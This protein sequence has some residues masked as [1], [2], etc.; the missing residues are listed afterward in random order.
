MHQLFARLVV[1]AAQLLLISRTRD[2]TPLSAVERLQV[3]RKAHV[4]ADVVQVERAVVARRRRREALVRRRLLVRDQP[5]VGHLESEA[6]H[7]AVRRVLLHRLE[8]ERVVQQVDVV[9]QRDL[10]QPLARQEVPPPDAIDDE[11]VPR[12]VAQVEGFVEHTLDLELVPL[13]SPLEAADS[14]GERLERGRPVVF[15]AE[16][17]SDQVL[18]RHTLCKSGARCNSRA[19][20]HAGQSWPPR[21][22]WKFTA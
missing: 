7:R 5:R 3:E 9:H 11:R 2:A 20:R 6:H 14:R 13:A 10:L 17:E 12:L 8:R 22:A 15:G 21:A 18:H 16:H 19:R 4:V 1:A